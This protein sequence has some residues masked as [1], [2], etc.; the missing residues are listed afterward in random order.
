MGSSL[1]SR[2]SSLSSFAI[3]ACGMGV[4]TCLLLLMDLCNLKSPIEHIVSISWHISC[5]TVI[6]Q[7]IVPQNS[8]ASEFQGNH[9]QTNIFRLLITRLLTM[10]TVQSSFF[11]SIFEKKND[12]NTVPQ[13]KVN[14]KRGAKPK[15]FYP[16]NEKWPA[17]LKCPFK[18]CLV[19]SLTGNLDQAH[20][21]FEH[22][23]LIVTATQ[24]KT[25]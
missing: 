17:T 19:V 3:S 18:K 6:E 13:I 11:F 23:F 7:C 2:S 8:P 14:H 22:V 16:K 21:H 10:L 9:G 5:Y 20:T 25:C 12:S 4:R 15:Q 1:D 24:R